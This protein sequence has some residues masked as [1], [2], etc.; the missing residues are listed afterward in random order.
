M[1]V[2]V[3]IVRRVKD[4][5][6]AEFQAALHDFLRDSFQ[7]HGVHGANLVLPAPGAAAREYGILRSFATEADRAAFYRSS[8][9]LA[10]DARARVLTEGEATHR[11]LHGMEAWFRGGGRSAPPR[12]KMAILTFCAVY[13]LTLTLTLTI[14]RWL[15]S[16]PLPLGNAVF[17]VIVVSALT[18]GVMPLFTQWLRGWLTAPPKKITS[19]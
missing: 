11:E 10:W 2:H 3:A 1:P 17:N 7:E 18:W 13:L 5:H 6:E 8:A 12:W 19:P 9:F 15:K 16:W 14:G 4:G